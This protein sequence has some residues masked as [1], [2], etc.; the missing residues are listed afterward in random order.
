M[1]WNGEEGQSTSDSLRAI[2]SNTGVLANA[3]AS[4]QT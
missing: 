1:E 4:I 3:S 2:H